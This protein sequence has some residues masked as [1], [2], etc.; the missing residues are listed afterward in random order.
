MKYLIWSYVHA[1]DVPFIHY[2]HNS[3][4]RTW[5]TN[6]QPTNSVTTCSIAMRHVQSSNPPS[7]SG[8]YQLCPPCP[9]QSSNPPSQSG[10]YQLC[11]HNCAW[12]LCQPSS[13]V[14]K[15]CFDADLK[16]YDESDIRFVE[17]H[18]QSDG[19][20]KQFNSVLDK[21]VFKVLAIAFHIF[22]VRCLVSKLQTT[23]VW[24]VLHV[25]RT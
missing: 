25:R 15:F 12:H 22:Q 4:S 19:G 10:C 2:I 6:G 23:T 24:R 17:A 16:V 9:V 14:Q 13:D 8:C 7:Q 21:Q 18:A 11:P 5:P 20:N 3:R 1:Y